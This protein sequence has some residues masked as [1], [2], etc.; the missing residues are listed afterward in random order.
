MSLC[1]Q[2]SRTQG[3]SINLEPDPLGNWACPN[4]GLIDQ[5]VTEQ[6]QYVS[7]S[8]VIGSII[9]EDSR[10]QTR[11]QLDRVEYKFKEGVEDLL[12]LYLGIRSPHTSIIGGPGETLR[13]GAKQWFERMREMEKEHYGRV[14]LLHRAQVRRTKYLVAVAIKFAAQESSVI[15]LQNKLQASG[16]KRKKRDI[17]MYTKG[18]EKVKNPTL[19]EMFRRAN[20]FAED[21]F[22]H[23]DSLEYLKTIFARYSRFVNFVLTPLESNLLY[24]MQIS[25][26]LRT[27]MELPFEERLKQLK[28]KPKITKGERD[29]SI[30]DFNYFDDFN[31]DKVVPHAFHL[32][33]IQECVR[34]WGNKSSPSISIALTQWA[35]QSASENV[36][37]QYSSFQRELA[38]EYDRQQWVS[39]ERFRDMR[40]MLI[41]WST[42]ISD[43][44]IPFPIMSLPSKGGFGDGTLGFNGDRR[45]P[46]PEI[47]LAVAAAPVLVAHWPRVLKARLRFRMTVMA[48]EDE[49]W[50]SR[51]LFVVSAQIY[52]Y[53]QDP[54]A[55]Q[56]RAQMIQRPPSAI[57]NPKS[58]KPRV[59]YKYK[60]HAEAA[61]KA[62]AQFEPL[63]KARSRL[64]S[65]IGWNPNV[66]NA[67]YRNYIS[68][69]ST[70][71]AT[72]PWPRPPAS[73]FVPPPEEKSLQRMIDEPDPSSDEAEDYSSDE[74]QDGPYAGVSPPSLAQINANAKAVVNGKQPFA[75]TIGPKGF[76]IDNHS[77]PPIIQP[78]N[79]LRIALDSSSD[80]SHSPVLMSRNSS[81]DSTSGAGS[82]SEAETAI[83]HPHGRLGVTDSL[84][85]P[86]ASA[87]SSPRMNQVSS[88]YGSLKAS[89]SPSSLPRVIPSSPAGQTPSRTMSSAGSTYGPRAPVED[90][91]VGLLIRERE[92]YVQMRIPLLQSSGTIVS[93]LV[94]QYMWN[95]I[96]SQVKIG[97]MPKTITT[98]YLRSIG[99]NGDPR[100]IDLGEWL[101]SRRSHW[102]PIECLLRAGIKPQEL[103]I[104]HI[105]YSVIHTRLLLHH[106]PGPTPLNPMNQQIDSDQLDKELDILFTKESG[107]DINDVLLTE[108]EAKMRKE[109]YRRSGIWDIED[110]VATEDHISVTSNRETPFSDEHWDIDRDVE[111]DAESMSSNSVSYYNPPLSPLSNSSRESRST[112]ITTTTTTTTTGMSVRT[113]SNYNTNA[114]QAKRDLFKIRSRLISTTGRK[115][116]EGIGPLLKMNKRSRPVTNGAGLEENG[117]GEEDEEEEELDVDDEYGGLVGLNWK[118]MGLSE[119]FDDNDNENGNDNDNDNDHDDMEE[120]QG[121]IPKGRGGRGRGKVNASRKRKRGKDDDDD[122]YSGHT[123]TSREKK[124]RV[125]S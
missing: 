108:K 3:E 101:Q 54:L 71:T 19:W 23:L 63:A 104:Q 25:N 123:I 62:I 2:C 30:S 32:Y 31:W 114:K 72:P 9:D 11:E 120:G 16:I 77:A 6:S 122:E 112:T 52:H 75:F 53:K 59:S 68:S 61:R 124:G 94:E 92:E 41:A 57:S 66:V 37:P 91:H 105:P 115:Q 81:L 10:L 113:S 90:A 82:A 102:S 47:D 83:R 42:S 116:F 28:T 76:N 100:K 78:T 44:G 118:E 15:I 33:Q 55:Q 65:V 93:P 88:S 21:S 56:T 84:S 117:G 39:A 8:N 87:H 119:E 110:P 97:S 67:Q 20:S 98:D 86:A 14:H 45:R 26:R 107:E 7:V 74:G 22:G 111:F 24:V 121:M 79:Q 29:W 96:R 49:I 89:P 40:N 64:P 70:I 34:L 73:Q 106:Y 58:V 13:N 109:R 36:M 69:G 51:K 18:D 50:L 17:P 95:W 38:A 80:L 5:R 46:I 99:V 43:A 1:K 85:T 35:I 125:Q 4:C 103:P 27:L 12:N 60:N 48:L